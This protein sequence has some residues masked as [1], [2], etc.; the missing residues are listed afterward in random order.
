MDQWLGVCFVVS[1]LPVSI[2][3]MIPVTSQFTSPPP[4]AWQQ[5]KTDFQFS[6]LITSIPAGLITGIVGV[7]RAISYATLIFSGT[8]ATFLPTGIGMAVFST[9]IISAAVA[10]T[11]ALP[12]MIATPL[13]APTAI[14][15]IMAGE[16]SQE[17]ATQ[18]PAAD[19]L[20]TVLAAIAITSMLTGALFIGLAIFELGERIRFV[21]YPVIGGFMAGTGWLLVQGFVQITIGAWPG[22]AKFGSL[23]TEDQLLLWVPGFAFGLILLGITRKFKQSWVLSVTLL[24]CA[25]VFYWGLWLTGTSLTSARE[26]GLLLGPFPE[27]SS[28]L[29]QPLTPDIFSKVHWLALAHQTSSMITIALVCLLSILLSNS[30]I[31][32]VAGQDLNLSRELKA[33]GISNVLSGLGGGMVGTQAMPSTLLVYDMGAPQYWTGVFSA[34]PAFVVLALGSTFLSY[35]PQAVL[36]CLILY[37]GLLLLQKWIYEAYFTLPFADYLS[38]WV[39]LVVIDRVG[40]LQG[41]IVGFLLNALLFMYQYSQVDIAKQVVSGSRIHS[42]VGRDEA[43]MNWLAEQGEQIYVLELQGFLFFGTANY[44]LNKV[45]DRALSTFESKENTPAQLPLRYVL[46]DFRQVT[47]LDSSAVLTFSKILK[48][49]RRH[50]FHLVLTNLNPEFE[51]Q[52]QRGQGLEIPSK[53]CQRFLDI[54][55]GLEWCEQQILL[56]RNSDPSSADKLTEQ[57][58]QL[59]ITPEQAQQFS[60]YLEPCSVPSC[61]YIFRRGEK[62]KDLYF[63]E[64]GQVSVLLDMPDGSTKRLQ[65]CRQGSVLGEMRFFG[66][67]PLSTLVVTDSPSQLYRLSLDAFERMKTQDAALAQALQSYIVRLLCNS[68]IR[69]EEQLRVIQ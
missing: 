55:R 43:Q 58:T 36:G 14:L 30:S 50:K 29:W 41:M 19:L 25:A 21:P 52:L 51:A 3:S 13:A 37:L 23:F 65:T 69:R 9:G 40:F 48:L 4:T 53:D 35:L 64:S 12:G 62:V 59:F 31:E 34:L 15:A 42:N 47:G 10:V 32:L 28:G 17:L 68:L 49:A 22:W 7:I 18:V 56:N 11:S 57:L 1:T 6:N 61:H 45:R 60:T 63:V 33:V 66:Q 2:L 27:S 39:T 24:G 67:V 5:L 20:A 16:I 38:I 54:D 44:L 46:I 8:L 26:M